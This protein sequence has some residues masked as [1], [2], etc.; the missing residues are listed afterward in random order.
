AFRIGRVRAGSY[1]A[2]LDIPGVLSPVGFARVSE[3]R[4]RGLPDFTEARKFF[5]MV[6]VDGKQDSRVTVRARRGAA[7]SG[8]VVYADGDPAVNVNVNLMRR[9]P[10]GK[11]EKFLAG[12]NITA[13]AGLKTDDRG[14]FRMSGLPP[15]EYVIAVSEQVEH[16]D[17]GGEGGMRDPTAGVLEALAGQQFLMTFYPSATSVKEAVVIKAEAGVERPGLDITIPDRAL[18]AVGGVVR[19]GSD[20][21]PVANARVSIVSREEGAGSDS[22]FAPERYTSRNSTTTGAD[23]RW[24]FSEIPEGSYTI[25][26]KPS[27]E[28]EEDPA[29]EVAVTNRNA[30]YDGNTNSGNMNGGYGYRGSRR[31]KKK[32]YAPARR[33]LQVIESDLSDVNVELNEGARVSGSVTYEGD[34]SAGYGYLTLRRVPEGAAARETDDVSSAYVSDNRFD[35]GGLPAGKYFLRFVAYAEEGRAFV[36]SM[37]W[38]G[39]DLLREPLELGEGA[40]AE[41]VRVTV[42]THPSKLRVRAAGGPRRGS[43][44]GFFVTL[45]PSDIAGWS[46]YAQQLS[47]DTDEDGACEIAAPPGEYRVVAL[48]ASSSTGSFEEEL[49]RRALTAPRATLAAGETKDFEVVLPEK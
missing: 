3:M 48:P 32:G 40:A 20:K 5:D 29:A 14:V 44:R 6:E 8:R 43:L 42:S 47:C 23:G 15:G 28:S 25:N 10:D 31:K 45:I 11:L 33:D 16:G 1:F 46:P 22:A 41:G 30:P 49:K 39:R 35:L 2:F 24:E 19:G 13:L 27:E 9:G 36:K 12:I 21:R 7:L 4:G 17:K 34:K 37:T 26:V 38:N 18:H